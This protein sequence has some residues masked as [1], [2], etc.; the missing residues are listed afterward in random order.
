M[1]EKTKNETAKKDND[2]QTQHQGAPMIINAQYIKDLSFEAPNSPQIF[3][4]MKQPP[5][6]A[7][8]VDVLAQKM[9]GENMFNVDLRMKVKGKAEGKTAFLVELTYGAVATLNVQQEAIEPMLLIETPRHMFPFIREI[10]ADVTTKGGFPPLMITP[11]DF[12]VLYQQRKLAEQ[13][14]AAAADGNGEAKDNA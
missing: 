1:T 6:I 11:I 5:E 9:A 13:Q 10:I 8:D 12:T 7:I 2:Q 4:E 14:N 3:A